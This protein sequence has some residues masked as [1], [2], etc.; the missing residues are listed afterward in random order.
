MCRDGWFGVADFCKADPSAP[1]GYFAWE[2]AGLQW[3]SDAGGARVVEVRDV[4]DVQLVLE[5]VSSAAPTHRDARSFGRALAATHDAG[6]PAWGCGP[7]G[8]DGDG[9]F[10]PLAQPL[11]MPLGRW[12]AWGPM[13]AEARLAPMVRRCRDAGVYEAREAVA[14][15]EL[16]RRVAD[17]VFDTD[18]GPSRLHGDLWSGNLMWTDDGVTLIEERGQQRQAAGRRHRRQRRRQEPARA[19]PGRWRR[20]QRL[21]VRREPGRGPDQPRP[22]RVRGHLRPAVELSRISTGRAHPPRGVRPF[23]FTQLFEASESDEAVRVRVASWWAECWKLSTI[24]SRVSA[25][26]AA[27]ARSSSW[28][29]SADIADRS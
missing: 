11:P 20:Q 1:P 23:A 14:L 27:S 5:R 15:D 22:Q 18:D 3:L 13:Y 4:S 12:D 6:A 24:A 7:D 2:A 9:F 17:G 16:T 26:N 21:R 19:V 8:W 25:R 28:A 29:S 10:G